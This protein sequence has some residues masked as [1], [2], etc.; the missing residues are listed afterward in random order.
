[1]VPLLCLIVRMLSP[2]TFDPDSFPVASFLLLGI[3]HTSSML[4]SAALSCSSGF[5]TLPACWYLQLSLA[6][7]DSLHFQHAGI[8]SSLLLLGIPHTPGMLVSAALSCSSGFPTLP[9][10]W[11]LQLSL[12]P[13]DS[14]HSRHAGICSSLLLLG[15]P[16]T[17]SMLVSAALFSHW[18]SY[19]QHEGLP[20]PPPPVYLWL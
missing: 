12:A 3:P 10:C 18:P 16:Y 15:I 14:P 7:R 2:H 6:P 9:A 8:C 5:P 4:V 13:R 19:A 1:M 11:Y 17:S 20:P